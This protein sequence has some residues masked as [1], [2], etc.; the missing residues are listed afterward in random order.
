MGATLALLALAQAE[1]RFSG[2][3]FTAPMLGV[4]TGKVAPWKARLTA[5][6][7]ILFG[8]AARYVPGQPRDPFAQAFES[9]VLTHDR[10]R[11][12]RNMGLLAAEPQLALGAPTWG[13]LDFALGACAYLA[14]PDRLSGVTIPVVILQAEDERLVDNAAQEAVARHLPQG[15]LIRVPGAYHEILM[16]TDPMRDIIKRVFDTLAGRSAPKPAA[17][18]KPA[19]APKAEAAAPAPAPE[20][21]PA[22]AAPAAPA[23]AAAT[24]KP[25]AKKAAQQ[26][27][28]KKAATA[29]KPAAAPKA[30]KPTAKPAA[31]PVAAKPSAAKKPA[32]AVAAVAKTTAAKPAAKPAAK[33]AAP[34]AKPAA[35]PPKPAAKPAA[36]APP[37]AAAKAETAKAALAKA[38]K[39]A[40]AKAAAAKTAAPKTSAPKAAARKPAAKKPAP[41]KG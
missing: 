11:F 24:P 32:P 31:K 20:P 2:A 34:K 25:A 18:P 28:A 15:Q 8:R 5:R 3:L 16:E 36:K 17:A 35:A 40:P 22:A 7:Q 1:H 4:N 41:A 27:A 21:A 6:L 30:A 10:A 33:A 13:W 23:P 19:E 37:K 9:N 12:A 26:P 39:P 29:A 38:A 14:R